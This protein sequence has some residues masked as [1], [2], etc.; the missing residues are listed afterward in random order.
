[1]ILDASAAAVLLLP[2]EGEPTPAFVEAVVK[3]PLWVPQHWFLEIASLVRNAERRLRID[4]AGRTRALA[5]AAELHVEIDSQTGTRAWASTFDLTK[6]PKLTIYDAA[7]LE[8]A[9]RSG[10]ALATNDT[11]LIKIAPLHG[12]TIIKSHL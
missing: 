10:Q 9:I 8:L 1:M 12:V 6:N 2:D 5:R 11:D 3:G 7:Y 4:A